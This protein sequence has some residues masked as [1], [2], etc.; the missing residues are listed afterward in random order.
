[1]NQR[2]A[3]PDLV[4]DELHPGRP[5]FLEGQI[6]SLADELAQQSHDLEDGLNAREVPIRKVEKLKIAAQVIQ[7]IHD[8]YGASNDFQKRNLL[9]RGIIHLCVT[10]I[11]LYSA[12]RIQAWLKEH[13]IRTTKDFLPK[14]DLLKH[15]LITFSPK[16]KA[17]FKELKDFV[18]QYIIN[19]FSVNRAD[20]RA[21]HFIKALFRAYYLNPRQ[22]QSYV[23]IK[24]KDSENIPYLRDVSAAEVDEEIKKHYQGRVSFLRAIGDHIA[25]MSDQYALDEYEKL[26]LPHPRWKI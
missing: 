5:C 11:V 7:K 17:L 19:S 22:L 8:E 23:L 25:G 24:F 14:R 2:I 18:H 21:R 15:N 4:L 20:G 26:F 10:D 9:I 1:L 12:K 16:Q 6:V 13:G 3:Y